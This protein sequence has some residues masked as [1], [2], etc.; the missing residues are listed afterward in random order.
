MP[1][2]GYL[3]GGQKSIYIRETCLTT[4]ACSIHC[5]INKKNLKKGFCNSR[6]IEH[7]LCS[8]FA[9]SLTISLW[10]KMYDIS[11][12]F[13][14]QSLTWS[15]WSKTQVLQRNCNLLRI[16]EGNKNTPWEPLTSLWYFKTWYFR[17]TPRSSSF[18]LP[19]E[20]SASLY[21]VY[22]KFQMCLQWLLAYIYILEDINA[23]FAE[24]W[25]SL[26]QSP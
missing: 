25:Q 15:L 20:N 12:P 3:L 9:L 19:V 8:S 2:K 21:N 10:R 16:S 4:V 26:P 11:Q 23:L 1:A 18:P 17:Y 14:I 13:C 6:S 5:I 22:M 7:R 24:K